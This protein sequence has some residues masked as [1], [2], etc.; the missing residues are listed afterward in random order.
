M[1]DINNCAVLA[2]TEHW[3]TVEQLKQIGFDGFY[4]ASYFCKDD[5]EHRRYVIYVKKNSNLV[6]LNQ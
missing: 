3:K 4:I 1:L 2:V 5:N 6:Y